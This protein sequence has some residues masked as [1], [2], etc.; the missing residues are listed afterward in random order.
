MKIKQQIPNICVFL[1]ALLSMMLL[2]IVAGD[3]PIQAISMFFNG[4]FGSSTSFVE[5]FIKAT[6]LILTSLGAAV[7][8]KS[9]F[10][11]IG[12]EGQFYIGAL[13]AAYFS[14]TF[15][16]LPPVL[17]IA[18]SMTCAFVFGG[19]WAF[20][21]AYLKSKLLISEIIVTIM[22]NYIAINL[23]GLAIRTFLMDPAGTVPQSAKLTATLPLLAS[24]TRLNAGIFIALACTI[25]VWILLDKTKYGFEMNVVGLNARASKCAGISVM[26]NV[27]L[28]AVIS[29]GLGGLAG[30]IEVLGIHKRLLEGISSDV[31][32]TAVL[33]A[34]L[35]LNK[36]TR[37]F[38]IAILFSAMQIGANSMQR[39]LGVP[40][41]IVQILIGMIVLLI[42]ARQIFI[43]KKKGTN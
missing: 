38:V 35:A 20:I 36:P 19:L 42:I 28:S 25:I 13:S 16:G 2:I 15:T 12:L 17:S 18:L 5:V 33:I 37:V 34:L 6:P 29:G 43:L 7:A 26:K 3:N 41:S 9:G 14:L 32:Y 39:Q 8:F 1:I 22:L 40:S 21:S 23:V 24:P 30:S 4:I 27:I 11:N 10:F 31:G